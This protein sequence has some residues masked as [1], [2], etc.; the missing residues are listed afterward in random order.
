MLDG[1]DTQ[2]LF[3][4]GPEDVYWTTKA[5]TVLAGTDKEK[6]YEEGQF[7][8]LESLEKAG[9]LYTKYHIDP[10]LALASFADGYYDPKEESVQPEAKAASQLF[11]ENSRMASIVPATQEMTD[12]NGQLTTLK[13]EMIAKVVMGTL[14]YDEALAAFNEAGGDL[15]SAAIVESLNAL[16]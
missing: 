2:M 14:T 7:H 13:N 15:F 11:S 9:T 6:T 1:G 4:Y 12:Y 8:M 3:T 5:G 16:N 10:M